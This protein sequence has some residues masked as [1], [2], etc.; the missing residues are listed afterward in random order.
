MVILHVM[1]AQPTRTFIYFFHNLAMVVEICS[2]SG[3]QKS[4]IIAVIIVAS[5]LA[6]AFPA[7]LPT[8]FLAALPP[9]LVLPTIA[10]PT[11]ALPT[12]VLP[13]AVLPPPATGASLR[14]QQRQGNIVSC[15]RSR[16]HSTSTSSSTSPSWWA[17][18]PGPYTA[19]L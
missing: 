17:A 12:A 6:A 19:I 4:F 9:I 3:A 10:L 15:S 13:T 2:E 11:A 7:A 14:Y 5:A 1:P 18:R 16:S 8:A